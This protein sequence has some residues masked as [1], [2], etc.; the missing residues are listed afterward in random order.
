MSDKPEVKDIEEV[1]FQLGV[2]GH[3]TVGQCSFVM[4]ERSAR[5]ALW[6]SQTKAGIHLTCG[7]PDA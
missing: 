1:M 6:N 2:Q 4:G 7:A 3:G 5:E